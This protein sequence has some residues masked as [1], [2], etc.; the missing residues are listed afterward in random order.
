ML[1]IL[2]ALHIVACVE[3]RGDGHDDHSQSG[4]DETERMH[5]GGG[6]CCYLLLVEV[7]VVIVDDPCSED[8][9]E[10]M[11]LRLYIV[12]SWQTSEGEL[13]CD[14]VETI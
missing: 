6:C 1:N 14:A 10:R 4:Q 7:V 9:M 8:S 11:M 13:L 2:E 5:C 3:R 12:L